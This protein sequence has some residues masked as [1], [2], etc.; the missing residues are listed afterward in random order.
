M[1]ERRRGGGWTKSSTVGGS[2]D[3]KW[4][5][6]ERNEDEEGGLER[7]R[8]MFPKTERDRP[9]RRKSLVVAFDRLVAVL[10]GGK[11]HDAEREEGKDQFKNCQRRKRIWI[12]GKRSNQVRKLVPEGYTL[13]ISDASN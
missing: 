1:A 10:G 6:N 9:G 4:G 11:G 8:K 7:A 5:S 3:G 13:N 12:G 2:F